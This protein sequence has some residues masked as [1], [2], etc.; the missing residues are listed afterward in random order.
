M[1]VEMAFGSKAPSKQAMTH[2][3]TPVLCLPATTPPPPALQL[4]KGPPPFS[5]SFDVQWRG[6]AHFGTYS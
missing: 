2:N 6:F 5:E 1:S 3:D 4:P